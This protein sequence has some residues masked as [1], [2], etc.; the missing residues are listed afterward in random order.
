[1]NYIQIE[2]MEFYAYHGCF[3]EEQIVGN[4]FLVDIKLETDM[5]KAGSTDSLEFALNYATV[6]ELIKSEMAIKSKLLE[7]VGKRILDSIHAQ[8][9]FVKHTTL[10]V[11]KLNPPVGGRVEKVSVVMSLNL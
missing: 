10:K 8:F 6:Y 4:K 7:N 5:N 1:M 9:P 11:S 3:E 2:G